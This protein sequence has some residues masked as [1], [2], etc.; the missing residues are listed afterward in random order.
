MGHDG[1]NNEAPAA[2]GP[3]PGPPLSVCFPGYHPFLSQKVYQLSGETMWS[4]A[5]APC[6]LLVI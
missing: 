2:W 3:R 5:M 1:E 6:V 4:L